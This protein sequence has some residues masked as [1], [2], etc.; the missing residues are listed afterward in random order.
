[1]LSILP[2]QETEKTL[3][4]GNLQLTSMKQEEIGVKVLP[5]CTIKCIRKREVILPL[6]F[7]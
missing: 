4:F 3:K 6:A 1:M 2:L 7:F 5:V